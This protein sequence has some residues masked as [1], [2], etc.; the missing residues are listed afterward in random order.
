MNL[1]RQAVRKKGTQTISYSRLEIDIRKEELILEGG[2]CSEEES[3][4]ID[5]EGTVYRFKE[6]KK[7]LLTG[8]QAMTERI[9]VSLDR[10]ALLSQYSFVYD[11]APLV[12]LNDPFAQKYRPSSLSFAMEHLEAKNIGGE[13]WL[14]TKEDIKWPSDD[15]SF[16]HGEDGSD[17][18]QR[19]VYTLILPRDDLPHSYASLINGQNVTAYYFFYYPYNVLHGLFDHHVSD[20]EHAYVKYTERRPDRLGVSIHTWGDEVAFSSA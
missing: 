14:T 20:I 6:D 11:H 12:W 7:L 18:K 3:L 9:P 5:L 17:P 13:V 16:F 10:T 2:E 1:G 4:V 8:Q 19:L 15:Q